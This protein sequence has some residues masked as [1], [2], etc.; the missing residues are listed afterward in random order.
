MTETEVNLIEGL[1]KQNRGAQKQMLDSYGRDVFAQ[2]ARLIPAIEDAE[3][4]YQDVFVKVFKNIRKYDAEKS[5]LRKKS[6]AVIYFEDNGIE[7]QALTDAE[8]GETF[9]QPN[10]ETVQLIRAALKHLPPE[11]KAIITMFY[12]EER[13]L[14]E[15]AYVTESIP[16]TVASKLSRTRRKLCRIIKMLQS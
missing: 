16:T 14:K 10:A 5:F 7:A 13:S 11:E 1:L 12:Y 9:G 3:E 2:I 8:V 15:I 6:P 4:V